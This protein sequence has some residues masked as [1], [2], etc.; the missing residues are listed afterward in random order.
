MPWL[1]KTCQQCCDGLS[2][3]EN[4]CDP[5]EFTGYSLDGG[6]AEYAVANAQFCFPLPEDYPA[7]QVA[8]LLCAG[9]IGYRAYRMVGNAERIGFYGFGAAAHILTQVATHQG[10]RVYAFTRPG[11]YSGQEFA[12]H[13]G[14]IWAGGS[15]ERPLTGQGAIHSPSSKHSAAGAI[16]AGSFG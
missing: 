4:L 15:D 11:D 10:R 2:G 6:Y 7:W 12:R 9:L 3:Q 8:P 16:N 14:A 13:L 1:G 5:A